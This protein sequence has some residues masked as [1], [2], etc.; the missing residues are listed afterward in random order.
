MGS[1]DPQ[2][3]TRIGAMNRGGGV[4]VGD[5]LGVSPRLKAGCKAALRRVVHGK[6]GYRPGAGAAVQ[7]TGCHR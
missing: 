3:W 5:R 1:F 7:F 4:L 2:P 6:G